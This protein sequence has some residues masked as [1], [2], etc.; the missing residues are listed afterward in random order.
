MKIYLKIE[1]ALCALLCCNASERFNIKAAYLGEGKLAPR[2]SRQE[3]V[4][5]GLL[6][7]ASQRTLPFH[8]ELVE[9]LTVRLQ[10]NESTGL[11]LSLDFVSQHVWWY[12]GSMLLLKDVPWL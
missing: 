10:T 12:E 2:K 9:G 5:N 3:Y 6:G 8:L 4:M 1:T 11:L 7:R